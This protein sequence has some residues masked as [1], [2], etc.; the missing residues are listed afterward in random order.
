MEGTVKKRLILNGRHIDDFYLSAPREHAYSWQQPNDLGDLRPDID[1]LLEQ[2][3]A[4]Q[5][6]D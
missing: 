4:A 6:N 5:L 3:E 1:E 2:K